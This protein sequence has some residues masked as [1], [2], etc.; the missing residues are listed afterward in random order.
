M[1]EPRTVWVTGAASGMGASHAQRFAEL[2]D[3]V[4]CWDVDEAELARVVK[5]IRGAGGEAEPVVA[6]VTDWEAMAAG[7]EGV[8]EA[9]G[10]ADVVV[11]NA[12]ILLGGEHIA[13][14]DPEAWRRVVDVNLTGAFHTAKAAIPQL[15]ETGGGSMVLVSSIC[16][17][18]ASAGY[19]AYNASKHGVIGLMRTLA[20]ELR[21]DGVNVNAVCPGW[22]R[23]PMLDVSADDAG[24]E[25]GEDH[26]AFA[27][28]TMI[29]RLIEPGEVTDAVVW[30]ASA[31]ARTI[32]A[33]ALPV[34]GGLLETRAWPETEHDRARRRDREST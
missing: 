14:L 30:L 4:G 12:G 27:S 9:L 19:G 3:R 25:A 21:F 23:T 32:T 24:G 33:V 2:G 20:H 6:D 8:R 7:A 22:V 34:E 15:R 13:E 17:L 18:T 10:P 1:S 16:G 31:A 5:R 28:M 11:A 26:E 29:D